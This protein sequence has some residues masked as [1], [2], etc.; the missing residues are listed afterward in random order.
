MEATS[1]GVGTLL[2]QVP[3]PSCPQWFEPHVYTAPSEIKIEC[4]CYNL[5][6]ISSLAMHCNI[7]IDLRS[8]QSLSIG[9]VFTELSKK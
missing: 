5:T 3:C 2:L 1:T 7:A 8:M 9:Q 6:I 4:F